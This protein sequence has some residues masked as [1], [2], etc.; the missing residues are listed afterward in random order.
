VSR[1]ATFIGESDV[2]SDILEDV[3]KSFEDVCIVLTHCAV[4][5]CFDTVGW[6]I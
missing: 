4:F 2:L 5:V 3:L 1:I 6:V